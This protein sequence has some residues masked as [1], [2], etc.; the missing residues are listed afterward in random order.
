MAAEQHLALVATNNVH[1]ATP[2]EYRLTQAMAAVRARRSLAEMDGWL[3]P[4]GAHLR[5]GYEM[6]QRFVRFPGAVSHLG[7]AG[8]RDCA[9]NLRLAKPRLPSQQVPDG[10]SPAS[11]LRELCRQGMHR[12]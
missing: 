11:W 3:P 1:F 12:R 6:A 9:F 2:A 10:F 4:P 8:D 5:S 7:P